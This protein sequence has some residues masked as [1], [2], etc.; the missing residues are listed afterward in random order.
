[1]IMNTAGQNE[2]SNHQSVIRD[3]LNAYIQ[4]SGL[5]QRRLAELCRMKGHSIGQSSISKILNGTQKLAIEHIEM[6]SDVLE[7]PLDKLI[8]D[9]QRACGAV[10]P[11]IDLN[12]P[13]NRLLID[14]KADEAAFRAYLGDFYIYFLSTSSVERDKLVSGRIHFECRDGYCSADLSVD[15]GDNAEKKYK[16]QFMIAGE[17]DTGYIFLLNP[18][19]GEIT[20]V[21]IRYKR[22]GNKSLLNR[23]GLVL[24]PS[25]GGT[26]L[27]TVG[28][29]L[30]RRDRVEGE[31][32][33]DLLEQLLKMGT[34]DYILNDGIKNLP[35]LTVAEDY[36][37]QMQIWKVDKK[38]FFDRIFRE[39]NGDAYRNAA[40]LFGKNALNRKGH[41]QVDQDLDDDM[42]QVSERMGSQEGYPNSE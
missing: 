3:N 18:E 31:E 11:Y 2:K 8:R 20:V 29:M 16:G 22:F 39:E 36:L 37:R 6:F 34:D 38:A 41:F 10:G 27:P 21:F 26:H 25:A 4:M 12:L 1:M 23:V 40:I 28:Y 13:N 30:F 5:S 9:P 7:V 17:M 19:N 33:R 24:T 15:I 42:Y 35:G 32:N 14:P